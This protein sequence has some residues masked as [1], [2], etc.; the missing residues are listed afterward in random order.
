MP[1][2]ISYSHADAGFAESLAAN[3][4]KKAKTSVWIDRWELNVGDSLIR[5]IEEAI[6]EASAIVVVL[7]KASVESE[8]VRKELSAGL[9][10]ELEEKRVVVLPILLEDCAIPLFLRDKKYADFRKD[11][12][13]GLRQVLDAIAK[14]TNDTQGRAE[15]VSGH[16]DWSTD[17][18]V[19]E[20]G[21]V[22]VAVVVVEQHPDQPF[23]L[24]T[25]ADIELNDVASR[26]HLELLAVEAEHFARQLAFVSL[27]ESPVC[28]ELFAYLENPTPVFREAGVRDPKTGCAFVVRATCR[29]MGSDTGKDLVLDLGRQLRMVARQ[30]SEVLKPAPNAAR[31]RAVQGVLRK[32]RPDL[33][34]DR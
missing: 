21:I 4:F 20:S 13:T 31:S 5:R 27:A 10:R 23:S 14:V 34:F 12:D 26:R 2:F 29:R 17:W 28:D 32:Y 19:S 6:T 30:S 7:S 11:F 15:L 25:M 22:T 8:W 33:R 18:T 9:I 16:I 1:V 24:L 3:I